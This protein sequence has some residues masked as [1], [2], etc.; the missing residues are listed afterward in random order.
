MLKKIKNR[1]KLLFVI[2]LIS[3]YFY[4][5]NNCTNNNVEIIKDLDI[6]PMAKLHLGVRQM[7]ISKVIFVGICRDNGG[8]I[9]IVLDYIKQTANYFLDYRIIIFENDSKDNTLKT[10]QDFQSKDPNLTIISKK[11]YVTKRPSIKFLADARNYYIN[12]MKKRKYASFDYV[13]VVDMDMTYG[14]DMRSVIY[15]FSLV[16][17]WDVSCSNGIW[18]Q[19][20][21]MYDK[22]AFRKGADNK[23]DVY[24]GLNDFENKSYY[25]NEYLVNFNL[26]FKPTDDLVEVN[27]CFGGLAI[28]KKRIIQGCKYDSIKDDCEHVPFNNCVKK[29]N[30]G[31][32]KLNPAQVIR[33]KHYLFSFPELIDYYWGKIF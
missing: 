31:R 5:F 6:L 2:I 11:F 21:N 29:K 33:Y 28:Y 30:H 3:S 9:E 19:Y 7:R 14:W 12:E 16:N 17:K 32:I 10:L 23:T 1:H 25:Y 15:P 4:F 26:F 18:N 20:Y 22:F 27:S 24:L 13:I 8:E